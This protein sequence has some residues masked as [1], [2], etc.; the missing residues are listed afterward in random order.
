MV[1]RRAACGSTSW[2][3]EAPTSDRPAPPARLGR[4]TPGAALGPARPPGCAPHWACGPD[5]AARRPNPAHRLP[6]TP[7]PHGPGRPDRVM[8]Q[9]PGLSPHQQT[10]RSTTSRTCPAVTSVS[11]LAGPRRSRVQHRSPGS[12][13][14]LQGGTGRSKLTVTGTAAEAM[15]STG[16]DD[17]FICNQTFHYCPGPTG[18]RRPAGR[19]GGTSRHLAEP[20]DQGR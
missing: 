9:R 20:S 2:S 4:A 7:W 13:A 5:P 6:A 19:P 10:S 1:R 17:T 11:S 16:R 3:T 18:L 12:A 14:R 8:S 15:T